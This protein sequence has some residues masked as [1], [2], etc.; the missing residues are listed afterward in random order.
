MK[1]NVVISSPTG[2]FKETTASIVNVKTVDGQRGI[3]PGHMPLVLSLVKGNIEL[4]EDN[5]RHVYKAGKGVL[6]F[7]EN[8]CTIL[9]DYCSEVR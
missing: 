2:K 7:K 8:V 4:E 5:G 6:Y 1:I 9:V 3:L